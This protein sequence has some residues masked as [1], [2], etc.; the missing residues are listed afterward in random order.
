MFQFHPQIGA[1]GI[2]RRHQGNIRLLDR[3]RTDQS[4][5]SGS[6]VQH[7]VGLGF[8]SLMTAQAMG[9]HQWLEVLRIRDRRADRHIWNLRAA[10][11]DN[12]QREPNNSRL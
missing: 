6:L 11:R 7:E 10:S 5:V 8:T 2:S 3:S 4:A 1:L 12:D 9:E